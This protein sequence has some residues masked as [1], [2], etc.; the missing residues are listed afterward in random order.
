MNRF[1]LSVAAV[2]LATLVL[3]VMAA[4]PIRHD[5]DH[6]VLLHQYKDQ[7]AEEDREIDKKLAEIRNSNGGKH[8]ILLKN[9][10]DQERGPW[11]V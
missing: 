8:P 10:E 9:S 1:L 7:W 3:P 2:T 4:E 11:G 5:A 6:Y